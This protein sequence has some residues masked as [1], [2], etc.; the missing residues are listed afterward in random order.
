[1]NDIATF[2]K[3]KEILNK[4]NISAKKNYGQNFLID[5]NI[6]R[7]I[8]INAQ[9]DEN[10]NV[11]EIGPGIGSLTQELARKA[12]KV[13]SVEIDERFKPILKENLAEFSN[14]E[15]V[16]DDFLKLDLPNFLNEHF[17]NKPIVVVANLPYYI[18]TA[19]LIKIFENN[20]DHKIIK[21]CAM[22][23]KEVGLRLNAQ[24]GTKDYN[25]L[26]ILT[27]YYAQT[28]IVM[29]I[30]KNVFIPAPNVDSVVVLF[31]LATPNT[32]PVNEQLFF[33]I[34]RLL[35]KQRRKTILNN[36]NGYF[37]DKDKTK[38]ILA[39]ANLNPSLRAE[40]LTLAQIINLSDMIAG[41]NHDV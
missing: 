28:K 17:D 8:V 33:K 29:K 31:T 11:L 15:I 7:N 27:E 9:V 26:S 4:Y 36:L 37:N 21:I 6:T 25:S 35:F 22:M 41:E 20:I 14:L 10:V 13:V 24:P 32:K 3:T 18:T 12:H 19:I 39:K 2:S 5:N 1:M 38:Q 40:N 23:Q 30:P 34:L 16:Y